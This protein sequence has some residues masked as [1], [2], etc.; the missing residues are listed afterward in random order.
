MG[1]YIEY[2][3]SMQENSVNFIAVSID[4]GHMLN[5]NGFNVIRKVVIQPFVF[6][7]AGETQKCQQQMGDLNA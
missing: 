4:F 1:V 3:R 5:Y 6:K 2:H 7:D